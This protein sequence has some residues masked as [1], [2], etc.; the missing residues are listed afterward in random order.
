MAE[1]LLSDDKKEKEE[2]LYK[3]KKVPHKKDDMRMLEDLMKKSLKTK[4]SSESLSW[5][6]FGC[7]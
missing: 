4:R 6:N 3:V 2:D 5:K 1:K 7:L